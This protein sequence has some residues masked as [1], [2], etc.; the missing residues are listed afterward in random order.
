M[1]DVRDYYLA[2]YYHAHSKGRR[3]GPSMR[4]WSVTTG[5]C[6]PGH[7]SVAWLLWH[8]ARGEDWAIQTILQGQEQLLTREGWGERMGVTYPGFGGGWRGRR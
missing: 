1:L 7:N 8:N 4:P 5:P 3:N 6:L 2:L